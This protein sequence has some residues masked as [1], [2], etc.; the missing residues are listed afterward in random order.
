MVDRLAL[1]YFHTLSVIQSMPSCLLDW[2]A[3]CVAPSLSAVGHCASVCSYYL[4]CVL[5][6][7]N[8]YLPH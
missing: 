7:V 1:A 6:D 5:E 3:P 2:S 8:Y 4:A